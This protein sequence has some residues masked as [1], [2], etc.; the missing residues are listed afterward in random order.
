[1]SK[2]ESQWYK[3]S[4]DLVFAKN[5]ASDNVS[6]RVERLDIVRKFSNGL[7]TMSEHEAQELGRSEI[8]NH[9]TTYKALQQQESAFGSM[10]SGMNA[11]VEIIVDTDNAERDAVTGSRM[12]KAINE[13]AIHF[14]GKVSQFWDKIAGE[15]VISG[16]VPVVMPRKY[17]W[18]PE[19]RP[20]MLFP[21]GTDLDPD[22]VPYAFDPTELTYK[23]LQ[24]L[25]SSVKSDK[26]SFIEIKNLKALIKAIETQIEQKTAIGQGFTDEKLT[27]SVRSG[28]RSAKLTTISAWWYY[29]VKYDEDEPY[30]SATLFCE[31]LHALL[32]NAQSHGETTLKDSYIIAYIPK[33]Y[34]SPNDWLYLPV[35]DSE[36]G[37]V[38]TLD[39]VRGVAELVY[40]SGLEM[41]ELLNLMLEGDKIRAKPKFTITND[42]TTDILLKFNPAT[43]SFFPKGVEEAQMRGSSAGLMTPF[44]LLG[45]NASGLTGSPVS[46]SGRGGELRVQAQERQQSSGTLQSNRMAKAYDHLTCIVENMVYRLLTMPLKPGCEGYNEAKFI[47]AQLDKYD[48]P[49]KEL[50]KRKY[51]R[52]EFIRVRVKRLIGNGDR[53]Q[54]FETADWFMKNIISYPPES[55]P[56]IVHQATLLISQDPDWTDR[57]VTVP[58]VIINAQRITAE[59]E[60]DTIRRR[61]V[62]GQVLP[63]GVDDIDQD[64]IP[65][66]LIDL[67]ALIAIND[68]VPWTK[69]DALQFAGAVQHTGLHVQRLLGNPATNPEGKQFLQQFQAIVQAAADI[70]ANLQEQEAADGQPQLDPKDRMN[71]ELQMGKLQLEAQKFG[72]QIEKEKNTNQQRLRRGETVE[73]AQF[74][75][76]I[77]S[78]DRRRIDRERIQLDR[79]TRKAP[80]A[81]I[82]N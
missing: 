52:F 76:E 73:R 44:S 32:Q 60:F 45:Q 13:G 12:S 35:I 79:E 66:H 57:L 29:E 63:I 46:N 51:G 9:L 62:L 17:G 54:Q 26:G 8:T 21:P 6:D 74:A 7:A 56:L 47:R 2:F 75:R 49:Y 33:A 27:E 43:D 81:Q 78:D 42:L 48:I 19:A 15:I 40:P 1:M 3:S 25:L 69:I 5:R 30:V 71:Y 22:S 37:G 67:E 23:A 36:I 14:K 16:G 80:P 58:Q 53:V 59:N 20:N 65:S 70:V 64:H 39:T 11:L 68:V 28:G 41:E 61:A 18:M 38:K 31:G 24:N 72:F 34:K 10:V 4:E 77:E 55:R 82:G 50:A